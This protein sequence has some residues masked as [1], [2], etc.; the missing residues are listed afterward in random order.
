MEEN[1]EINEYQIQDQNEIQVDEQPE[2]QNVEQNH[3]VP[4]THV[5]EVAEQ[6]NIEATISAPE[7]EITAIS[8]NDLAKS[9][10][11][12]QGL[13]SVAD[14]AI[15]VTS[16][17][18]TPET[19]KNNKPANEKVAVYSTKNITIP[20]LGK[21]YRGYNIVTKDAAN[22]WTTKEYIR[23]ATPEEVAKEFGK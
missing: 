1:N 22:Q 9:S 14:G 18:R 4:E 5:A 8:T 10:A 21:V 17:R 16:V 2:I 13:G 15:G 3:V 6:H 12:I 23:L 7:P 19:P 11:E 20:G